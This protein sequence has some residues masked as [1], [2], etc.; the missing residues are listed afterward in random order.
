MNLGRHVIYSSPAKSGKVNLT[1]SADPANGQSGWS[2]LLLSLA[3]TPI[4]IN[5]T[6][7]SVS[8]TNISAAA[9]QNSGGSYGDSIFNDL[10]AAK[11]WYSGGATIAVTVTGLNP[12]KTYNIVTCTAD[13][14]GPGD[15]LTT[16]TV[17][18]ASP[19]STPA[20]PNGTLYKLTF[21]G[22][23]P[24]GSGNLIISWTGTGFPLLNGFTITEN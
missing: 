18:S 23:S 10:I 5:T 12:A 19:Q 16:V 15:G 17:G 22:I 8:G 4:S 21:S 11:F 9:F 20:E 6:G 24:D 1:E 2:D 3:A 14:E 7:W 13:T